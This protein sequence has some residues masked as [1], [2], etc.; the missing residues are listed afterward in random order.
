MSHGVLFWHSSLRDVFLGPVCQS[1]EEKDKIQSSTRGGMSSSLILCSGV[2]D[3]GYLLPRPGAQH[4]M[5]CKR[6]ASRKE[7]AQALGYLQGGSSPLQPSPAALTPD[8]DKHEDD[9]Y[10]PPPP[11]SPSPFPLRDNDKPSP[12]VESPLFR[13][14]SALRASSEQGHRLD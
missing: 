2:E 12:D 13:E 5:S 1:P 3:N 9:S 6:L 8:N 7:A 11:P 10:P 14:D 4:E